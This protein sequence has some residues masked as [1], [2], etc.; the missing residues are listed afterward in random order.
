LANPVPP[1]AIST[2]LIA[3]EPF[4][5]IL[6]LAPDPLP[7][8]PISVARRGVILMFPDPE[9]PTHS[10]ERTGQIVDELGA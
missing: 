8:I 6:N 9:D 10:I 7:P 5:V 4:V 2:A 1:A 3:P